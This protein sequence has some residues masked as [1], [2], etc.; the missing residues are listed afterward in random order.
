MDAAA[1]REGKE[2]KIEWGLLMFHVWPVSVIHV[3][4]ISPPLVIAVNAVLTFAETVS[5]Y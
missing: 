3:F 5:A 4:C 2:E 1:G